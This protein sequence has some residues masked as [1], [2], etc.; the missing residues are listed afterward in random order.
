MFEIIAQSITHAG[1]VPMV[2]DARLFSAQPPRDVVE[3]PKA[4]LVSRL[5]VAVRAAISGARAGARRG[6]LGAA[7]DAGAH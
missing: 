6:W 1:G 7:C 2:D 4:G 3:T 5:V